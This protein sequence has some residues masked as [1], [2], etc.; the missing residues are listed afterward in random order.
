M[1]K[2]CLLI[3]LTIFQILFT[4]AGAQ[5]ISRLANLH[6]SDTLHGFKVTTIYLNDAN[7]PMGG[8]FIHFKTGFTLDFLQIESVPQA[9]FWVNTFPVSDKGEPHTQEHYLAT[10]FREQR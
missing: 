2:Y 8:R 4:A 10:Y 5:K 1:K 3:V 9:F 7:R 6:D